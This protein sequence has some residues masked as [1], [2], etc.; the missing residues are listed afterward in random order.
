MENLK[1]LFSKKKVLITGHTGFKG[2]WLTFILLTLNARVYGISLKKYPRINL[3]KNYKNKNLKNY[4]FDIRNIKKLKKLVNTINPDYVF[5]LAAQSLVIKSQKKLRETLDVNI[6]GTINV[7]ESLKNL[8][9]L[10]LIFITT[11]DKV[12]S[13]NKNKIFYKEKDILNGD[14][15]YEVSKVTQDN[16]SK[17]YFNYVFKNKVGILVARAGNVI[18]GADFSD[19]RILPDIIKSYFYK[20]KL[21]LRNP[22]SVRPFQDI[23]D[24]LINYLNLIW[25]LRKSKSFHCFNVGP[26]KNNHINVKKLASFFLSKNQI[27]ISTKKNKFKEKKYLYLDTKKIRS[28]ITVY[29]S[30]LDSTVG[31]ILTW[32]KIFYQKR[33]NINNLSIRQIKDYL[34]V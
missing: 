6:L 7:L 22:K 26:K 30:P 19:N 18:G 2:Y 13:Q 32:Y 31:R 15:P 9:N 14:D 10:K 33:E 1:K 8:R 5:H 12:Y 25:K 3:F 24:C 21:I 17:L 27:K 23:L 16:L 4:Y 29:D 28:K 34:N 20:K 11:T